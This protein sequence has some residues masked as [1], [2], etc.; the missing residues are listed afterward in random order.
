[1][2]SNFGI[3]IIKFKH[4]IL[5][6]MK[7]VMKYRIN[8]IDNSILAIDI[9]FEPENHSLGACITQMKLWRLP[10]YVISQALSESY[11]EEHVHIMNYAEMDWEDKAWAK[12]VKGCELEKDEMFLVH[13]EM[14]KTIIK[15]NLFDKILFDYGTK[16]LEV[17]GN[18]KKNQNEYKAHFEWYYKEEWKQESD[19]YKLYVEFP[20]W[21]D[22]M[23][24]SLEK[25]KLKINNDY[26]QV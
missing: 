7:Y 22:A 6:K 12:N 24:V 2:K 3:E 9:D 15:E 25:L 1:M 13:D 20:I 23:T 14:G 16:V 17:Y 19:V 18:D 4:S 8:K 10:N 5:N 21:K 26:P 11:G